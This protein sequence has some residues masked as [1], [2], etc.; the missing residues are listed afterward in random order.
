LWGDS[1]KSEV[2]DL[3]KCLQEFD[4]YLSIV[5]MDG[6]NKWTGKQVPLEK[7][8]LINYLSNQYV[9]RPALARRLKDSLFSVLDLHRVKDAS[10]IRRIRD[11]NLLYCLKFSC[12]PPL[13]IDRKV[14]GRALELVVESVLK[15]KLD[16]SKRFDYEFVDWKSFDYII[17]DK[18]RKDWVA[19]IQ[20]KMS[21]GGGFLSYQKELKNVKEFTENFPASKTFI[22]LCGCTSRSRKDEIKRAFERC[23]WEL[24]YLWVDNRSDIIDESFYDFTDAIERIAKTP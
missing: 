12:E 16:G 11:I 1:L 24:Y 17:L 4:P 10:V 7:S 5:I 9:E 13:K 19:G 2:V 8:N 3:E 21:F 15:S 18:D 20:C 6:L 22:M 23:G 14:S